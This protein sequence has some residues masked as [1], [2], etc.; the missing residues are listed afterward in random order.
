MTPVAVAAVAVPPVALVSGRS[1]AAVRRD[2]RVAAGVQAAWLRDL[3]AGR[4]GRRG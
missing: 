3:A 2:L 1:P 4:G